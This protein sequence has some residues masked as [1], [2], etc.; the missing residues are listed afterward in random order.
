V[1]L[2]LG[3][4]AFD[5]NS[6]Q[7]LLTWRLALCGGDAELGSGGVGKGKGG[8][9]MTK[10]VGVAL[11]C[12]HGTFLSMERLFLP[13]REGISVLCEICYQSARYAIPL[14]LDF[15][16]L[17]LFSLRVDIIRR[18]AFGSVL[19]SPV[20]VRRPFIAG[21]WKM[22]GSLEAN[23]ALLDEVRAGLPK[24]DDGDDMAE[25]V[26]FT[27]YPYLDQVSRLAAG[28]RLAW[29]AQDVSSHDI[30]AYTGEVA[31]SML[32]DFGCR[33]ALVGHSE[34]RSLHGESDLLVAQKFYAL[35]KAGI[36]PVLCLGETLAERQ[37]GET[38]AVVFRQLDAV[39][40]A[41]GDVRTSGG[42]VAFSDV[43]LAYEPVWA[44]GS[45]LTATPEEAEAVHLALRSHVA[46]Q[47]ASV[48]ERLRI[49][50]GGSVKAGNAAAL[51]AMP[52]IDGALVGG[53][54][55]QADEFLA[56][57]RAINV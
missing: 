34:R 49:V 40:L 56:I 12:E 28:S 51:F 52:N 32:R 18:L 54:A 2:S 37:A 44:I 33:Y 38:L 6:R 11:R 5:L 53:A 47:D 25:I 13:R 36:V 41:R 19:M 16:C 46:A 23:A 35:A 21:N 42:A 3:T 48:A 43:V 20:S 55:L 15:W 30:G 24:G 29:G 39:V 45:G 4:V 50:Y 31:A 7:V 1:R 22:H 14:I 57:C 17:F 8:R 26:V 9:I 10:I 27:P